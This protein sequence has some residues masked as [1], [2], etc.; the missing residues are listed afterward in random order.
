MMQL[1]NFVQEKQMSVY[2]YFYV[3]NQVIHWTNTKSIRL[4]FL[5]HIIIWRRAWE[6]NNAMHKTR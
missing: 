6:W 1:I 2:L 3:I 4:L 5:L